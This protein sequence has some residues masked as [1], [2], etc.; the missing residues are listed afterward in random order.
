MKTGIVG[1]RGMV[2]SVLMERMRA[3]GDFDGLEPVFFSHLPGGRGGAGCGRRGSASADAYDLRRSRACDVILTCQGG[4][5]TK[6]V[7]SRAPRGRLERLLDRRGLHPA[8]E[9]RCSI[10]ILDPVNR[11]VIDAALKSGVRDYI[12][13]NCT[14]SPDAD[15]ARRPASARTGGVDH[16]R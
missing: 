5:Y 6:A 14:V 11:D 9:G 3:E 13:G 7:L 15:G 10:I 16:A 4:D 8:H 1:W 12:G 2:G